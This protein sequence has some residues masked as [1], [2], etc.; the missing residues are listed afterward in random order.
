MFFFK[1]KI[2]YIKA[3]DFMEYY[4]VT[5]QQLHEALS[6]LKWV[7]KSEKRGWMTTKLGISN[8]A[9]QKNLKGTD[10]VIWDSNIK[11]NHQLINAINE[12]KKTQ[13]SKKVSESK[14]IHSIIT[15]TVEECDLYEAYKA[16]KPKK[17]TAKEKK[18]KGDKYEE[19]IAKYFKEQGYY[20]WEHGKEKGLEDNN[21][22]LFVKKDKSIY[23]VQCKDWET[24]KL[25]HN[26]VKATRM[27]VNDYLDNNPM[28]KEMINDFEW[29]V[30][31]VTS[32]E[33]LT[34]GAYRYIE[35]HKELIE[36]QVIP[37]LN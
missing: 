21:I 7:Q 1:N 18:E 6:L 22:D 19:Y 16:S 31:Y 34:N 15:N 17:M 3:K 32:K 2:E 11:N 10:Y 12:L 8:G 35:E 9:V 27:D 5:S 28:L 24:W 14:S 29:K 23:F 36:Y 4:D 20:V 37:I 33:C 25:D 13:K 30:L 26:K